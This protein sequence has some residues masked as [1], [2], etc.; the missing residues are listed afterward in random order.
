LQV[1]V[2]SIDI[3]EYFGISRRR[4]SFTG[5]W[6]EYW[7]EGIGSLYGPIFSF[8]PECITDDWWDLL[9]FHEND[10]IF[11]IKPYEDE[12]YQPN[13]GIDEEIDQSHLMIIPNP[14]VQGQS[15]VLQCDKGI[16]EVE[17]Y[18]SAGVVV[19]HFPVDHQQSL[20]FSSVQFT[21]GLYFTR[22][23]TSEN[24]VLGRKMLIR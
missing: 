22:I 8:A 15:F 7:V 23:G 24:Q 3:V 12:C 10:T 13:V 4:W 17:I 1:V 2:N 20:L 6:N 5:F 9:C 18:N 21:A 19:K 16:E 11:Y 14:V